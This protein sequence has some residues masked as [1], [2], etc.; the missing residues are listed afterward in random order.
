MLPDY[1]NLG[2]EPTASLWI[3]NK[4]K[5]FGIKVSVKDNLDETIQWTK[6]KID[7]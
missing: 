3:R 1:V 4:R 5:N 2:V 6:I 7:P